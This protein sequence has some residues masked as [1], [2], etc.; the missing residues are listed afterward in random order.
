MS[1]LI[2]LSSMETH[3]AKA[4]A[5]TYAKLRELNMIQNLSENDIQ[6]KFIE[7]SSGRVAYY[8]TSGNSKPIILIHGNSC[9]KEY[10]IKQ[11]DALGLKYKMIAIDL[12][13]HGESSNALN[14]SKNYTLTGYAQVVAEVI[15]K[16]NLKP[17]ILVGWSLGGH[18]A[19]EMMAGNPEL[20]QG[21]LI[22]SVPPITPSEQGLK[23]A[24]LPTYSTPLS[25]KMEPFTLEDA[26][27]YIT[28]GPIDLD[29]FTLLAEASMRTHGLARFTMVNAVLK[30][31]GVDEKNV[32][33]T[34]SI[35]L[36][37]IMGAEEH[38]V[39]NDYVKS[40]KY[41]NCI[42]METLEGGH[43]CQWSHAEQF[44]QLVDKFAQLLN[45]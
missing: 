10:M 35:P 18:I 7:T 6:K 44:N 3:K 11:L 41:A 28:Q 1:C 8:E 17:V 40:L 32:A 34:S 2:A 37:I 9:S 13:G 21:V 38:A 33:E 43:D 27:A 30:G 25:M 39:N 42:M 29:R 16:L 12:P 15:Q 36:G 24:Y 20:L 26:K 4:Y 31:K 19:L 23:E 14:P 45:E 22:A 5:P